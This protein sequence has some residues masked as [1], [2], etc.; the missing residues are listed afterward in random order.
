MPTSAWTKNSLVDIHQIY[1]R[2]SW[3]KEEQTSSGL[4]Q[5]KLAHYTEV[6]TANKNGVLP[7]RILVQGQ[8]GIGKSTFVK[9]LA[10]DWAE[11]DDETTG[12][13]KKDALSRFEDGEDVLVSED[14]EAIFQE[15][16][17]PS[18]LR[19]Q[20]ALTLEDFQEW[21]NVFQFVCGLS[22][23]GAVKVFQLL[24]SLRISDPTLD[25]SKIVPGVEN[26][27]V[28]PLFDV[29]DR[30]K[31]FRNVVYDTFQEVNSKAELLSHWFD[32]NG[33]IF[34]VS[35]TRPL[36]DLIP[37]VENFTKLA[38]SRGAQVIVRC[39]SM[40]Y[41]LLKFLDCLH[42]PISKSESLEVF[43]VEDFLRKFKRIFFF[44]SFSSIVCLRNGKFH[45]YITGL[46]LRHDAHAK[47][48]A[49]VIAASFPSPSANL[50]SECSCLKFLTSLQCWCGL[51]GQSCRALGAAIRDCE[52]LKRIA[53]RECDDSVTD[54]LEHVRKPSKCSL[55]IGCAFFR[56]KEGN[57]PK[58]DL[59][60]SGATKFANLT[61][62][63]NNIITL[64]LD[65]SN[66]CPAAVDTVVAS[67]THST[68]E[69]LVLHGTTL[70]PTAATSLCRSLHEMSSLK[71]LELNGLDGRILEAEEI[72]VLFGGFNKMLPLARLTLSGFSVR[73]CLSPL[74]KSL[75][76]FPSLEELRLEKLN[77]DEHDQ[78]SLL[79]S[80]GFIPNLKVMKVQSESLGHP[81]CCTAKLNTGHNFNS[82]VYK[83]LVLNGISLTRAVA[84]AFGRLL[85]EMSFLK[86]LELTGVDGSILQAEEMEALF[87]ELN[88]TLPLCK[89]TFSGFRLGGCLAPLTKGFRLFPN[90]KELKLEKLH[91]DENDQC[92]L[93]ESLPFIRN[94][95][96]LKIQT[97]PLSDADCC[98][99]ELNTNDYLRPTTYKSL[100][101]KGVILTQTATA[102][103][104][105]L[106]P[107]MLSLQ[108][109]EVTGAQHESVL[110]A[111]EIEALFGRFN[112]VLPLRS[113]IFRGFR[114]TGSIVPLTESF[115]FFP[116]LMELNLAKLDMDE[117]NFCGLLEN[118]RFTP[119]LMELR[120][121]GKIL[122]QAD[123]RAAEA[124]TFRKFPLTALKELTLYD[125]CL[126]PA[127]ATMLG[128]IL[129]EMS[130]LQEFVLTGADGSVVKSEELEALFGGLN[131]MLPLHYLNFCNF[132][133]RG[134]LAP[135]MKGFRFLP[136]L[137]EL[138][139]GGFR[140]KLNMDEHNL[141][142]LLESLRFIPNLEVLRVEGRPQAEADC[143]TAGLNVMISITHNTLKQ[144]GLDGI[145]LTPVSAALLGRSL[146]E[147]SSLQVL[148]LTGVDGSILQAK[149]LEALF[150]GVDKTLP[151]Y[152]LTLR[153][154]NFSGCLATL[155]ESF[156]FFPNL[157]QLTLGQL[158]MDEQDVCSLLQNLRFICGLRALI[159]QS[160]DQRDVRCYSE[161]LNTFGSCTS[162]IY[163]KL[164]LY[165]ISLTPA[166]AAAL[167]R[168]LP[169]MA[170]L[171]ILEITEQ[172][173]RMWQA[174]E[175][176]ALFGGLNQT[177][178]LCEVT[179]SG[180]NVRGCLS[181]LIKSLRFFP[182][183]T[184]LRLERLNM[185]EN[186]Q[187]GLLKSFEPIRNLTE[188]SVCVGGWSD[189]DSF[190]YCTSKLNTFKR[191]AHDRVETSLKLDGISLTPAVAA[192]LGLLLPE[193]SFLHTLEVTGHRSILEAEQMELLFGRFI[194][195]L[196]LHRLALSS[197]SVRGCLSPLYRNLLF[198]P[199][200]REL[201]LE[202]L[203][204]GEH[205][206][207]FLSP[208]CGTAE[209][210]AR[211]CSAKV[212]YKNLEQLSLSRI[213]LTPA[214]AAAL[215]RS[216]PEMS[217]LKV[218]EL[219]QMDGG[220][221]QAEEMEALF[222]QFNKPMPLCQLTLIGLSA[223]GCLSPLF[224]S[225]RF[226]PNLTSLD[227]IRLNMNEH[228]L[229][230]LLESFQFIPNLQELNLSDNPLGHAVTS[231][232]P[233]VINLKK[234]RFL[235]INNTSHSEEDLI[236]V[237]DNVQ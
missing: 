232:V 32:C 18:R 211:V 22:D 237:R 153:N 157:R 10:V 170:S 178:P 88:R 179:F 12:G 229:N 138:H 73:G 118:L 199:N 135:L 200:L 30:H 2:L 159:V 9:K 1:T 227:L 8:T 205:D 76:C 105:Q 127:V 79:Q 124:H 109:L 163:D 174:E 85:P 60:T 216:L 26:E 36:P 193:M 84:S 183:L 219:T 222:G 234:L 13:T 235:W 31:S 48:F 115:C 131:K 198:F 172:N 140:G 107:E 134:S 11:L 50:S 69:V 187:C 15:Y 112:G 150:G 212:T 162:E 54:L 184:K 5:Y 21:E 164:H 236:Y 41:E 217:S 155:C 63:F 27:T 188:L 123:C 64:C 42:E 209:G 231:I 110:Q 160:G 221:L 96:A 3:V 6:F 195:A 37:K 158:N 78:C 97:G 94:L 67:I 223:R 53:V 66:C 4:S 215:G 169:E 181:P 122:H 213:S 152:R 116:N 55:E 186:D 214:A 28:V 191:L 130:S 47:L 226:F 144:L 141:C 132:N 83:K 156:R 194:E 125:V 39:N 93:L 111:E 121:E 46:K 49:E 220:I 208:V 165:G 230:G 29:T 190:Y 119:N 33:G 173:I 35:T 102:A 91:M 210:K 154:F 43:T 17:D 117:L 167:G 197:F 82:E 114:V 14:S 204:M 45:F 185:D 180:F 19:E 137:R 104:G 95:M 224:R 228:D 161:E 90:L 166:A 233:H 146:P 52:H 71:I 136:K 120:V 51:S 171:Q 147:M 203:D 218:L 87:G 24:T 201:D 100:T 62:K 7:K 25:V 70:T 126:T 177:I 58:C 113:L 99:A 98:T 101:L 206:P 80:F 189:L 61:S 74:T 175:M 44:S 57:I 20:P 56:S 225:L 65:L 142:A 207:C 151:F 133:V 139:L 38:H 148:E 182:N 40:L 59:S 143:C 129:P 89:L 75:P 68:L 16:E 86:E 103:L 168:S 92:G 202:D 23:D 72:E 81:C 176:E 34:L 196:P 149:E 108:A 192:V 128:E 77:M 106:L 145:R